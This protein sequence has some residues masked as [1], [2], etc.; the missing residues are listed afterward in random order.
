MCTRTL[1][2]YTVASSEFG[3]RSILV[4]ITDRNKL[5]FLYIYACGGHTITKLEVE[6][7]AVSTLLVLNLPNLAAYVCNQNTPCLVAAEKSS[8]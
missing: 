1:L 2:R 3:H 8:T 7:V 6:E 4:E 5:L